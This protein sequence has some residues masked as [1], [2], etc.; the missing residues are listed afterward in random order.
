MKRHHDC[1]VSQTP[2][3]L[4]SSATTKDYPRPR[5]LSTPTISR[6]R[7]PTSMPHLPRRLLIL[8]NLFRRQHTLLRPFLRV[9]PPL[10]VRRRLHER[11]IPNPHHASPVRSECR[12]RPWHVRIQRMRGIAIDPVFELGVIVWIGHA[13]D[14]L[15]VFAPVSRCGPGLAHV[16]VFVW[17]AGGLGVAWIGAGPV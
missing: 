1:P 8:L 17:M 12:L 5:R 11:A 9:F 14:A 2:I 7:V 16:R 13:L 3:A 6:V 15:V 4:A 10:H